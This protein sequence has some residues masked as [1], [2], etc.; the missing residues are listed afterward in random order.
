[1]KEHRTI[2]LK[3]KVASDSCREL[4]ALL[5][6]IAVLSDSL[7]GAQQCFVSLAVSALLALLCFSLL[8][9]DVVSVVSQGFVVR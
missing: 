9:P 7:R 5:I 3:N 8:S 1:M 4:S 6:A 2:Y